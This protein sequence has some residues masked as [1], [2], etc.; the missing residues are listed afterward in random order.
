VFI[1][2]V[3][4]ILI[5]GARICPV[6]V[7]EFMLSEKNTGPIIIFALNE[8]HAPTLSRSDTLCVSVK[9]SVDQ[10]LLFEYLRYSLI[11]K[12]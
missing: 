2:I 9:L 8:H 10:C 1:L 3:N 4:L 6:Y 7:S 5:I 12:S 11:N